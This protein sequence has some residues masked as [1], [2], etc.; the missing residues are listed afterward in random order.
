MKLSQTSIDGA[1]L[2]ELEPIVDE[3]GYF[4]RCWSKRVVTDVDVITDL[5]ECSLSYNKQRGTLRGMHYQVVPFAETKLVSCTGGR[6]F[7]AIVDLR[8]DSRTY[9][10]SFTTELSL[11]NG[12]QLYVPAGCAHG[13]LTL[14]DET[15]VRY[16]ITDTYNSNA[17]RGVRW[18]DPLFAIDWPAEPS[19]IAER[20]ANYEDFVA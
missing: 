14:E 10:Q 15:Y 19:V 6:I 4:A 18:N 16:Q 17:A 7:D 3:R 5:P 20:D 8:P 13:F 9:L 11:N 2:V 12:L 1:Y